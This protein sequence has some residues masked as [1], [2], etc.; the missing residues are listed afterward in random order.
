MFNLFD[1]NK[2][3]LIDVGEFI[4]TLSIFHP[5]A[6]QAEKIAGKENVFQKILFFNDW[7]LE[8]IF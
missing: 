1:S 5:D 6:S 7:L 8:N 3:G 2:D 4:H